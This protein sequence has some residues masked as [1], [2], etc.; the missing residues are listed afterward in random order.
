M[1]T[2]QIYAD[3]DK[4]LNLWAQ[5]TK[6]TA[7]QARLLTEGLF[8]AGLGAKRPPLRLYRQQQ[9]A[10][11]VPGHA[12]DGVPVCTSCGLRCDV[13]T[14]EENRFCPPRVQSENPNTT[15]Q[16]KGAGG[17]S[18]ET[19]E[20]EPTREQCGA[21]RSSGTLKM[22]CSLP[23]GHPGS[24]FY[25]AGSA[26]L[27]WSWA[28]GPNPCD[29][30]AM[31]LQSLDKLKRRFGLVMCQLEAAERFVKLEG[32][33]AEAGACLRMAKEQAELAVAEIGGK[34]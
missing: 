26:R 7:E 12:Q 5:N 28:I 32:H 17:L 24:H 31:T 30:P 15:E 4:L 29:N 23:E 27:Y 9:H 19:T 25:E 18:D 16:V 3:R 8:A 21:L 34:K 2:V 33:E 1:K 22:R 13:P 14:T 10:W 20:V 11:L 6:E